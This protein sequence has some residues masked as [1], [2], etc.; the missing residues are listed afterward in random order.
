LVKKVQEVQ[1]QLKRL[2]GLERLRNETLH[3]MKGVSYADIAQKLPKP[4]KTLREIESDIL[5]AMEGLEATSGVLRP[6]VQKMYQD[7]NEEV[8]DRL[9]SH[10][11]ATEVLGE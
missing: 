6:I 9:E 3:H 10:Q 11:P 8:L 2:E 5:C 7:I 4:D 1:R